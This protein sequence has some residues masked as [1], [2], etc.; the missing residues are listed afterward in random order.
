MKKTPF[1]ALGTKPVI[2][3]I[4]ARGSFSKEIDIRKAYNLIDFPSKEYEPETYPG[5]LVKVKVNGNLKHITVYRN[6]KFIIAGVQSEKELDETYKEV[7]R[8][9]K[10]HGFL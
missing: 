4:V 5:L 2:Q 6:G 8:I 3:N 10:K 9:F 7:V 1:I